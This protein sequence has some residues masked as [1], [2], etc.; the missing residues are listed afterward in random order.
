T[1][2]PNTTATLLTSNPTPGGAVQVQLTKNGT[3][4]TITFTPPTLERLNPNGTNAGT[5]SDIKYDSAGRLHMIWADRNQHNLKYSVRDTSGKWS[6]PEV[7]DAQSGG[8][9]NMSLALD[10]NDNPGIAYCDDGNADLKYSHF[11]IM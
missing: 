5:Y 8:F 1:T 11:S 3:P 2:A 7:I 9:G 6:I 4:Q 10:N